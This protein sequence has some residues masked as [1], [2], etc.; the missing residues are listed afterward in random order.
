[1]IQ[2]FQEFG[3]MINFICKTLIKDGESI[4]NLIT[5]WDTE[6]S[7]VNCGIYGYLYQCKLLPTSKTVH[8]LGQL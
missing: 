7:P 1:M 8:V 6:M 3:I 4:I 5:F 2:Q